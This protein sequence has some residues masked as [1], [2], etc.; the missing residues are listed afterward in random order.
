VFG[1]L[2]LL[3]QLPLLLLLLLLLLLRRASYS[4]RDGW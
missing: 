2:I 1:L 3:W 4:P